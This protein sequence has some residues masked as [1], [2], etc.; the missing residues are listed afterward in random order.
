MEACCKIAFEQ[1]NIAPLQTTAGAIHVKQQLAG[2]GKHVLLQPQNGIL[3]KAIQ[4]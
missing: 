1:S 2:T 3:I 4:Q